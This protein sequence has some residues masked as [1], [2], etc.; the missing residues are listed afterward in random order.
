MWDQYFTDVQ[1]GQLGAA[2][3]R[4]GYDFDLLIASVIYQMY[5][6]NLFKRGKLMS[7]LI[8]YLNG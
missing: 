3:A 5:Q 2:I 6:N 8:D 7:V 4:V 1:I